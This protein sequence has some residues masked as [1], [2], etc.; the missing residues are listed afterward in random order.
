MTALTGAVSIVRCLMVWFGW[1]SRAASA[2]ST[3]WPIEP[4]PANRESNP[5][6]QRAPLARRR[7]RRHR[8]PSAR[9][10]GSARRPRIT[11]TSHEPRHV[12]G[13]HHHEECYDTAVDQ[14]YHTPV[15][16]ADAPE[17]P[18]AQHI[19][20]HGDDAHS[21]AQPRPCTPDCAHS[22][23]SPREHHICDAAPEPRH[24]HRDAEDTLSRSVH[25]LRLSGRPATRTRHTRIKHPL[26]RKR[27][28]DHRAVMRWPS[29]AGRSAALTRRDRRQNDQAGAAPTRNPPRGG[30]SP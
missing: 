14:G 3:R 21:Q 22:R 4:Q 20:H 8:P 1:H 29:L 18:D 9:S 2:K 28:K 7:P 27:R 23:Q 24:Q 26:W 12:E 5:T 11:A 17:P 10:R 15:A 16:V 25:D 19:E 6:R 13:H 30:F